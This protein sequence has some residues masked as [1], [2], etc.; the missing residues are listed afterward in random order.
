MLYRTTV[1]VTMDVEA[2]GESGAFTAAIAK[3]RG[4]IPNRDAWVTGIARD[5]DGEYLCFAQ[6]PQ[7]AP[8]LDSSLP[9]PSSFSDI[10]C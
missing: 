5:F 6:T 8:I 7:A 1:M 4:F 10:W 2:D 9:P 3:V